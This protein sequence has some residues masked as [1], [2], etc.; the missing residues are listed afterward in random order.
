[1]KY[2]VEMGLGAMIYIPSYIK[3]GSAIRKLIRGHTQTHRQHGDCLRVHL[4][5][6]DKGSRVTIKGILHEAVK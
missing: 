1:M 5:F 2:G 3:I 6:Q 4:R